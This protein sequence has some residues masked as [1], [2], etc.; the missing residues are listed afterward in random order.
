[1]YVSTACTIQIISKTP[2]TFVI[3]PVLNAIT[4]NGIKDTIT[5]ATGIRPNTKIINPKAHI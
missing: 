4:V 3:P 2:K 1:M 5:P